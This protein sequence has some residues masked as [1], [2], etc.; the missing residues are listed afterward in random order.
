MFS[1]YSKPTLALAP[2]TGKGEFLFD[3]ATVMESLPRKRCAQIRT[4][5]TVALECIRLVI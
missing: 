4:G 3:G 5:Y 1:K 2:Y